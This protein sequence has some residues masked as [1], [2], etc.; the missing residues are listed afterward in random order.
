MRADDPATAPAYR[1]PTCGYV[2]DARGL[3]RLP[4][5]PR[6]SHGDWE[7]AEPGAAETAA[8]A[9]ER[10]SG[11]LMIAVRY[12]LPGALCLAGVVVLAVNPGGFGV[13]GFGL[14]VGAGL[15]ILLLNVLFRISV[16][17]DVERSH[18]Q[19]AR[20]YYERHG[21]WPDEERRT[22]RR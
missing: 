22:P 15:S 12:V 8:R 16:S 2:L 21:R 14:F 17:G 3:D 19:E 20:D 1:C 6:C 18:E 5:C 4:A 7:P 11:P 10:T 13:E 9:A